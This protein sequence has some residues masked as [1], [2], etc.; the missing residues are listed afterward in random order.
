MMQEHIQILIVDD[1]VDMADSLADILEFK[2]Y[3]T[4]VAHSGAEA[5]AACAATAFHLVLMDVQM[6]GLSGIDTYQRLQQDHPGIHVVFITGTGSEELINRMK[7]ETTLD[8]IY[9]PLDISKIFTLVDSIRPP[10]KILVADAD[11]NYALEVSQLLKAHDFECGVASNV[12]EVLE[13]LRTEEILL[14]V[15]DLALPGFADLETH[16]A[17]TE[18]IERQHPTVIISGYQQKGAEIGEK[19][20]ENLIQLCSA[21]QISGHPAPMTMVSLIEKFCEENQRSSVDVL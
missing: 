21:R 5:I 11:P 9:K 2:S 8:V 4:T 14:L 15:L 16:A 17:L 6:P 18:G 10:G 13:A 20:V 7:T 12:N 19:V 3:Q 1:D